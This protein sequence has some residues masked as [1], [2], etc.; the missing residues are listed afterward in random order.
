M[1]LIRSAQNMNDQ[2]E[3]AAKT[4]PLVLAGLCSVARAQSFM[5]SVHLQ[6]LG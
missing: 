6:V 4:L 2:V 3:S 1:S 5:E